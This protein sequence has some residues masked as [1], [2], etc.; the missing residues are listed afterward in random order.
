MIIRIRRQS[1]R[2]L[3]ARRTKRQKEKGEKRKKK[4][5]TRLVQEAEHPD[6]TIFQKERTKKIEGK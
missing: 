3:L 6:S 4:I 5:K 1:P 2:H